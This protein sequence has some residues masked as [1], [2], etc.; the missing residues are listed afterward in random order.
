ML[1]AP[2]SF[3]LSRATDQP[4]PFTIWLLRWLVFR[5]MFMSGVVKLTSQDPTW[6]TWSALDFHY[7]TQPLPAWT[8]WYVH[9]MPTWFHRLSV[10]FMFFAELAAPFLIFG[11]RGMRRVAVSQ[12]W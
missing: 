1:L 5:L 6:W 11:T 4:W 7:E 3:R 2:W 12:A 8:S 10:G 9:Q